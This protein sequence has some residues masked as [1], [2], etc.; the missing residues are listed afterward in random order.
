MAEKK[1]NNENRFPEQDVMLGQDAHEL[2]YDLTVAGEPD[3]TIWDNM[4]NALKPD[5]TPKKKG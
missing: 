1:Q 5:L 3:E 4:V 2:D